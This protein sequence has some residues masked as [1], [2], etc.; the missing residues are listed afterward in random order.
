MSKHN[1]IICLV[2]VLTIS[3]GLPVK[4][5]SCS[6]SYF[7]ASLLFNTKSV[8]TS[9]F[10]NDIIISAEQ[11]CKWDTWAHNKVENGKTQT[12]L[13]IIEE[14]FSVY[15]DLENPDAEIMLVLYQ[16]YKGSPGT[17]IVNN[18]EEHIAFF[19]TYIDVQNEIWKVVYKDNREDKGRDKEMDL[20][21]V[22]LLHTS[23]KT[24]NAPRYQQTKVETTKEY[25]FSF[26]GKLIADP[27]S[28]GGEFG[29]G[30]EFSKGK[31]MNSIE[32]TSF[33]DWAVTETFNRSVD[34]PRNFLDWIGNACSRSATE[35]KYYAN[36]VPEMSVSLIEGCLVSVWSFNKNVSHIILGSTIKHGL[37]DWVIGSNIKSNNN[38]HIKQHHR[39]SEK[40]IYLHANEPLGESWNQDLVTTD[41]TQNH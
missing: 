14:H 2:L 40:V 7:N 10:Q 11:N 28:I 24:I 9:C 3:F 4:S 19:Q 30:A 31:Q 32:S 21:N 41:I 25:K 34:T 13:L 18:I 15:K 35:A 38:Y 12:S 29:A 20:T 8:S 27:K 16:K 5:N 22:N 36:H 1:Y 39:V 23:P 33:Q 6:L 26:L 37:S 17:L